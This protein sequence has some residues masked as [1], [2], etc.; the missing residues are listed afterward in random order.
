MATT[1]DTTRLSA[2]VEA[3]MLDL[4]GRIREEAT[5]RGKIASGKTLDSLR[6]AV[7]SSPSFV[8][9]TMTGEEQWRWWGNGRGPGKMPPVDNIR[10]WII[11]KGLDLSPYAVARKI[12][13]E[14]SRDHRLGRTNIVNDSVEA[15]KDGVALEAV[16]RA[17]VETFGDA[18]VR[19][20]T[21]TFKQTA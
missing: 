16:E 11:Q 4:L 12:A 3:A 15:W 21:N 17:G 20:V 14:G 18:Y 13:R 10:A 5:Y 9:G 19:E 1:V 7:L 2:A 6:V 8:V